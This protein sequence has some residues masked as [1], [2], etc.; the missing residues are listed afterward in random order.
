MSLAMLTVISMAGCSKSSTA[1][2]V[3]DNDKSSAN[4][5]EATT[6]EN[7]SLLTDHDSWL[8]QPMYRLA[9]T[10]KLPAMDAVFDGEDMGEGN[11][12][13]VYV[14]SIQKIPSAETE[15]SKTKNDPYEM[16]YVSYASVAEKENC[17]KIGDYSSVEE[18][19]KS[20]SENLMKIYSNA[21]A[22]SAC[23][24]DWNTIFTEKQTKTEKINNY[25]VCKAYYTTSETEGVSWNVVAYYVILPKGEDKDHMLDDCNTNFGMSFTL[26]Y[27]DESKLA[28]AEK[29][30]DELVNT[31]E[32]YKDPLRK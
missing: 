10:S 17:S 16:M 11:D 24:I 32:V 14:G 28:N 6:A 15:E 18:F 27:K 5:T 25:D 2:T 9:Y 8:K 21:F 31:I 26:F 7:K 30:L 23:H 19:K 3:K 29:C 13:S 12:S 1:S 4:V 22:V 20:M